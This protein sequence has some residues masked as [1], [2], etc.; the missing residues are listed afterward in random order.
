LP[1][2]L[3]LGEFVGPGGQEVKNQ[4]QRFTA[5]SDAYPPG[6]TLV[7]S[8]RTSFDLVKDARTEKVNLSPTVT[9]WPAGLP[10]REEEPTSQSEEEPQLADYSLTL[11]KAAFRLDWTVAEK[12]S[13]AV[14]QVGSLSDSLNRSFGGFLGAN[15][16]AAAEVPDQEE[17][18]KLMAPGLAEQI[19]ET[20]G[21]AY[22]A[23][24]LASADDELSRQAAELAAAGDWDGA[25]ALWLNILSQNEEYAPALY[26][27]GLHHERKGDLDKAWAF[28]RL[29]YLSS[30]TWTNRIAL[31]RLADSMARLGRTPPAA[32]DRP[33]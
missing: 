31:T 27:L 8:G 33:F 30:N 6:E 4:L 15:G 20:L 22:S 26:N 10:G 7:L 2:S 28:Y 13:G 19:V 23:T 32:P 1:S 12:N 11:I 14:V 16:R 25:S 18:V 3:Q 9:P 5:N 21:P 17:I 29:A 24:N